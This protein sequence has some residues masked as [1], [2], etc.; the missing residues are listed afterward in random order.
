MTCKGCGECYI[1]ETSRSIGER[2]AEHCAQHKNLTTGSVFAPHFKLKHAG[3]EQDLELKIIRTCAGDA[4]LR[5]VTEAV[6][7]AEEKPKL[8]TKM[9]WRRRV[10]SGDGLTS[11][12]NQ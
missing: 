1:G 2:F 5:Q 12:T 8:N 7:I 11:I 6:C 4:M 10:M 3:L 9:E